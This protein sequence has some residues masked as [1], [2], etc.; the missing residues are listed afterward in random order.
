MFLKLLSKRGNP[1]PLRLLN[2]SSTTSDAARFFISLRVSSCWPP[3]KLHH[4]NLLNLDILAHNL[5]TNFVFLS[6]DLL[7]LLA[8]TPASR[9]SRGSPS[10]FNWI[11]SYHSKNFLRFRSR[12]H[13]RVERSDFGYGWIIRVINALDYVVFVL[14]FGAVIVVF[15]LFR[16]LLSI[17]FC[18]P[19]DII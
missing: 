10:L 16:V 18:F 12:I 4:F 6:S 15:G 11:I 7:N 13:L 8:F 5:V 1:P 19:F 14:S 9:G 3:A 2:T 17:G